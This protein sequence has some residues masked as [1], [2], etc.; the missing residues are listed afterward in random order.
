MSVKKGLPRWGVVWGGV[1]Q[2]REDN[3]ERLRGSWGQI[4][5]WRQGRS[6][7]WSNSAMSDLCLYCLCYRLLR[8]WVPL[9]AVQADPY[10]SKILAINLEDTEREIDEIEIAERKRERAGK[11]V[12]DRREPG[13]CTGRKKK[14]KNKCLLK[15]RP[16]EF[17]AHAAWARATHFDHTNIFL[18][19]HPNE[20]L[21]EKTIGY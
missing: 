18:L 17:C 10:L 16:F 14:W 12:E 21:V 4:S 7:S 15:C 3:P 20:R 2:E 19:L 11:W 5:C 9:I 6:G 1:E 13:V 8:W